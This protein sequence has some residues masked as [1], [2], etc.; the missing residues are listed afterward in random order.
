MAEL[1]FK[2]MAEDMGAS[3][4][5]TVESRATSREEIIGDVGNPVYP[6]ARRE[7]AKHGIDCGGKRAEQLRASDYDAYDLLVAMDDNNIRNMR[8]IVGEDRDKK[9]SKLMDYTE[10]AGADVADPW[11]TGD[12][13]LTYSD[14]YHGCECLIKKLTNK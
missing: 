12:F 13:S 14:I 4:S 5:F 2:K 7:L 9:I 10:R 8:R 11:Y 1:I 6:P 3:D